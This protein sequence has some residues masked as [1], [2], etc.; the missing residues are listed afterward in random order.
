MNEQNGKS[1]LP[2]PMV[3]AAANKARCIP[4][5]PTLSVPDIESAA[6]ISS[7]TKS[8]GKPSNEE[9]NRTVGGSRCGLMQLAVAVVSPRKSTPKSTTNEGII[10]RF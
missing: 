3:I 4:K 1:N 2:M 8:N 7:E 10:Q 5:V 6:V 9:N